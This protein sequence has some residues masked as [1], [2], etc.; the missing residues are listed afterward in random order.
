MGVYCTRRLACAAKQ[1]CVAASS[2]FFSY[3][4]EPSPVFLVFLEDADKEETAH[5]IRSCC[6]DANFFLSFS[7][8]IIIDI[9][10]QVPPL[11]PGTNK[12]MTEAL[13]ASFA[14]WEKEQERLGIPKGN[15]YTIPYL[16]FFFFSL[17]S[18][19]EHDTLTQTRKFIVFFLSSSF[20]RKNLK[21]RV[22]LFL[23]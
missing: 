14:S 16:F 18:T 19:V 4:T 23:H 2:F 13:K 9:P 22:I 11:T 8:F 17:I 1:M 3:L 10:A 21:N 5:V 12:K 7:L 15:N 20:T 6:Y